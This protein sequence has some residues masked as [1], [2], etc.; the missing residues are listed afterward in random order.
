M[1]E[2]IKGNF[3]KNRKEEKKKQTRG[4]VK[5]QKKRET[6]RGCEEMLEERGEGDK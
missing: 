6:M 2:T 1:T 4:K 3:S 5:Q